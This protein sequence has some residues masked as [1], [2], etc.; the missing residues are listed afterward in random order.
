MNRISSPLSGRNPAFTL[1]ELMVSM[2]VL[3]LLIAM[4]AQMVS[5]TTKVTTGMRSKMDAD[6]QARLFFDRLAMDLSRMPSQTDLDS[7]IYKQAG[8]DYLFFYSEAPGFDQTGANATTLNSISLIGY[9]INPNPNRYDSGGM[10]RLGM[11]LSWGGTSPL[12]VNF[13]TLSPA[14]PGSYQPDSKS[15]ILG[16]FGTRLSALSTSTTYFHSVA[17]G[18]FRFEFFFQL[19]DGTFSQYPLLNTSNPTANP[20]NYTNTNPA[21]NAASNYPTTISDSAHGFNVNSRWWDGTRGYIC[22]DSTPGKAVWANAGMS[23]VTSMVAVVGILDTTSQAILSDPSTGFMP[24]ATW[25]ALAAG[26][27]DVTVGDLTGALPPTGPVLLA[28]KWADDLTSIT[29]Y[30]TTGPVRAAALS[31]IRIYQRSIPVSKD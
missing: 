7:L 28:K 5:S 14:T 19:S 15:T 20:P 6:G 30:P 10:D 22:V 8:N 4:V 18:I 24:V 13:L 16:T 2:A 12:P 11:R 3:V 25:N 27:E 31:Q 29:R 1:V 26:L 21:S 17:S 23:D 9:K